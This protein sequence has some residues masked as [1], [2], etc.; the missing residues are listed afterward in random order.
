MQ[1]ATNAAFRVI[2][3][4]VE[5]SPLPPYGAA[6]FRGSALL[7]T[8]LKLAVRLDGCPAMSIHR[9][10]H[11][12]DARRWQKPLALLLVPWLLLLYLRLASNASNISS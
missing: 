7:I 5:H 12:G 9:H 10:V 6:M 4:K 1:A 2:S 3:V 11:P 8:Y